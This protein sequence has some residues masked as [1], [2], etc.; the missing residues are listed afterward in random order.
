MYNGSV[1]AMTLSLQ[2]VTIALGLSIASAVLTPAAHGQTQRQETAPAAV[3]TRYCTGCHNAKLKTAGLVIDPSALT[4]VETNPEVWE[5]VDAKLRNNSMP[6]AGMPHP[7]QATY[8]S[9]A[10]FLE[11]QLDHAS[12]AKPN[13]GKLPPLHRLSR[14]EYQNATRD[15]LAVEALPQ[16]VNY[17]LLLPPD[18]V[19]SGFDN[20]ADLLFMS[21]TTMERYLDAA[22]KIS[23]LAVGDPNLPVMVNTYPFSPEQPQDARVDEL[24]F[25]TRGG[26]AVRSDFPVDGEYAIRV[27]LAAAAREPHQLEITVD[28][29]RMQIATIGTPVEGGRG[30]RGGR[31]G[32]GRGGDSDKPLEFRIPVK[33]GLRL[34]GVAFVEHSEARDE[35]VLRPRMRG[36]GTLPALSEV[37][38][39][40]PYGDKSPGD[41]PSRKRIFVCHPEN[42]A[43]DLPCAKRILSTLERRAYRRPV[44]DADLQ[45]LLPFYTAG[46]AAGGFDIGI[47]RALSR[48]LVSPQFLFR[49]ERDPAGTA[50]GS[51]YRASDIELASRLSFFLWSS[52]PDDELL[53]VAAR[54]KLKDPAVL[55]QQTKRMLADPRSESMVTN[56]AEQ[57][58]FL[59]DIEAKQPDELLFPDFDETLRSAMRRETELFLDSVLREN[60]SVLDLLTANYTF[61]N[62]RLARH[63]G[64]PNIEGSYFRRYTF[65]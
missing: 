9:V 5:K 21:P 29:Q 28:G 22:E 48:L 14:T 50:P 30:G 31:G 33:A 38:I 20:I 19:S 61:L 16:E 24:P 41:S 17:S 2:R 45:D 27:A 57:W 52:I 42:T 43:A 8:D 46:L 51:T 59:R 62:Q 23:K 34:I 11:T 10:K 32:G 25:G 49:V 65:P 13:P 64:V 40:G 18:N 63:Y 36:R 47:E 35:A 44:T 26:L 56:F 7:D 60:R 12:A 3:F 6:P 54:G 39:S 55:E 37:T 58:L 1:F 4:H 15:L 53:D